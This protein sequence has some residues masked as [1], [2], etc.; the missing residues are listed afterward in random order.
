MMKILNILQILEILLNIDNRVYWGLESTIQ[1]YL[2]SA[3]LS[4]DHI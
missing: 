4:Q 2:S 1:D 3:D